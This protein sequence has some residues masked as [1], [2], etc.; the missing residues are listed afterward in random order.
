[1]RLSEYKKGQIDMLITILELLFSE[2]DDECKK[3]IL[4]RLNLQKKGTRNETTE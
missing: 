1:M 2:M 4:D 3:L